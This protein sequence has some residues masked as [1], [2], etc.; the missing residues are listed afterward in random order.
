M[1]ILVVTH[2]SNFSGGAN[3]SLYTV[4]TKL[5]NEYGVDIEVLL[6]KHKGQLNEKLTEANIPWFSHRYFGVISGIRNDGK[7]VLRY[8]KVYGGYLI[9]HLLSKK[10]YT[11]LKDRNYDL[12]YT[13]TRLPIV[14]AKVAK[15]LN[16]PHV[17]HVREF[18]TVK[19]LW[20][21]WH[22]Q[23]MYELSSKIIL[24][25]H[26]LQRSFEEH[27]PNDKLITIHNGIDSPLGLIKADKSKKSFNLLLTGRLVPDK[28]HKDAILALELLKDKG[29][30]D[31]N[32]H[33]VGSS[34]K[35]THIGW[36]AEE[37][38]Q[39]VRNKKLK[40]QI[41]FHGEVDDMVSLRAEMDCELM[42][43]ICETFG[44]VT[45]EGMRSGLLLIG[46]N[47]GGTL[48]IIEHEKNGLLYEQG[49]AFDLAVKIEKVYQDREYMK[50]LAVAGYHYSQKNFTADKNVKEIYEVF[51]TFKKGNP[52]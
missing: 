43:A 28:G 20:G 47:T 49:N 44:R 31:I 4:L 39:L 51:H 25:S 50:K 37:L 48:E 21:F 24:I 11:K 7:D 23:K 34:P 22:H 45:V 32:L 10:L 42:C 8:G 9:E 18:G 36:Y 3:R 1:K 17:C 16:V 40:N 52:R 2:D 5:K 29:Y 27:V 30:E 46:S 6:P 38:E 13:N 41:M 15:K 35:R 33:I 19:P 14:G 12:V 26:A